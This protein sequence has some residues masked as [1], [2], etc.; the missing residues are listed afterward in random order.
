L[1]AL[2][3]ITLKRIAHPGISTL[4]VYT[5]RHRSS[6]NNGILVKYFPLPDLSRNPDACATL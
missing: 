4:S 6:E 1:I 2:L 3:S 5:E